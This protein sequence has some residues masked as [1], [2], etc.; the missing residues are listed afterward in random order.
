[1]LGSIKKLFGLEQLE[2]PDHPVAKRVKFSNLTYLSARKLDAL[3]LCGQAVV[4]LDVEGAFIECGCALGGSTILLSSLKGDRALYVHD[5]FG[6]MPPP[7]DEDGV[8]MQQR[9]K[10]IKS[11]DSKGLAGDKYYGYEEDLKGKVQSNL[12]S[13]EFDLERDQIHL[14]Q[15]LVQDTLKPDFPIALAHIDV[16]WHDPVRHC[17][18]V[19]DP[20]LSIGG[21]IILDDYN[22]LSGCRKAAKEFLE[23]AGDRYELAGD[24]DSLVLCKSA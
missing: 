16:D 1:M 9:Y 12:E 3:S 5:V 10:A 6:M 18:E 21:Y 20:V 22:E 15:G 11:G 7:T 24:E 2:M 19:I 17:L 4:D 23:H 13:F 8:D 14:V